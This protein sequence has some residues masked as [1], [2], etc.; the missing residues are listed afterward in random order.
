ML[1]ICFA[2]SMHVGLAEEW[3]EKHPCIRYVYEE[4]TIGAYYNSEKNISPYVS[5]TW[6]WDGPFAEL[7][8]VGGYTGAPIAPY[9]RLGYKFGDFALF[10]APAY[11]TTRSGSRV[12][13]VLGVEYKFQVR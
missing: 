4:F 5:Y 2:L 1:E 12:G 9:G 10:V 8:I 13:A 7:G 3:N 11:E 6:D